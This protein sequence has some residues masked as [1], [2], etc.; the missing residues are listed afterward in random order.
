MKKRCS[1]E[2]KEHY[3]DIWEELTSPELLADKLEAFHNILRSLPSG[4]RRHVK[5]SET[6]NDGNQVRSRKPE[7]L[8]KKEHSHDVPNERSP[9]Q[10]LCLWET[11]AKTRSTRLIL[12]DI[13]FC[14]GKGRLYVDTGSSHSIA[15][16]NMY[17]LSKNKGL[18]FQ[19]TTLAM[20]LVDGHQTTD[21]ALT[22][23][24]MIEIKGKLV[25][26]RFII[27]PMAKANLLGTDYLSSAGLVLDVKNAC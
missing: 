17:K 12:I 1:P 18:I 24:V 21:E 22:T 23:Q 10:M 3:Q 11:R 8:P 9:I 13:T 14:G 5:A 27:L 15:G 4:P 25:L 2:F 16:E 19:E 7:R 26:T 6:L 20:S